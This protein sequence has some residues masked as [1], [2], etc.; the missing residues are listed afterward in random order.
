VR[1]NVLRQ[2]A[3]RLGEFLQV[4]DG[5]QQFFA[6]TQIASTSQ[7]RQLLDPH[8]A[9]RFEPEGWLA[10]LEAEY[11]PATSQPHLSALEQFMF[12]DLS[13]NLPSQMLT[14]LDRASMAHS[15]EA[16]VP[17]LSHRMVDWAMTVPT[18]AKL[19]GR[20]GKYILR[21]AIA[22]WLPPDI[23]KRPKQGFQ[24]PMADWLRGSFGAHAQSVWNDSGAAS[25]GY[26]RPQAVD[27][28]FAEHRAGAA[29][30]SR[31]L[32]ALT[33]FGMWWSNAREWNGARH[34]DAAA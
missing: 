27:Q 12:A 11:F 24:I 31:L 2:H 10:D 15:V 6:A 29:D 34:A 28:L 17:F 32:Y 7:R 33:V 3:R 18:D 26:V 14:R 8:F 4:S 22:P 25:L 1:A 21:Q 19:R 5:Y 13:L 23:I 20:T 16:R 9:S 30:H